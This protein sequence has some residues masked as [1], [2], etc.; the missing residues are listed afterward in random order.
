MLGGPKKMI[1]M[2]PIYLYPSMVFLGDWSRAG[3]ASQVN[4]SQAFERSE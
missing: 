2:V 3:Y 1:I 4:P